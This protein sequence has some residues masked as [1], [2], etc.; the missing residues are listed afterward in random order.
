[1]NI[2][3]AADHAGL[4]HK[5][6]VA[7]WLTA[8]GYRVFDDGATNFDAE[9]DFPDFISKAA[10]AVSKDP[11]GVKAIIFGGSGQGEAMVANRYPNVRAAVFYGGN[12]KIPVLSRQHNDANILSVGARFVD[13]NTA[14]RIIWDWLHAEPFPDE[15]YARRNR[16]IESI[17]K[18]IKPS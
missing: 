10:S 17:T 12:D 1:M 7:D 4:E 3:L 5:Q 18:E 14:K 6:V 16:K 13:V 11:V 8:E 9:D 15:K 2:H